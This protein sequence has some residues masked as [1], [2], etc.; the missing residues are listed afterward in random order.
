MS[1]L[2]ENERKQIIG[3]AD[4][5]I[6]HVIQ[7]V[8]LKDR[9]IKRVIP[10]K[11]S[12]VHHEFVQTHEVPCISALTVLGGFQPKFNLQ[13]NEI[14]G[15]P[16]LFTLRLD[17]LNSQV[18]AVT[19]LPSLLLIDRLEVRYNGQLLQT[20][21]GEELWHQFNLLASPAQ[22]AALVT[23]MNMSTAYAGT[24]AIQPSAS[25]TYNIPFQCCFTQAEFPMWLL[26]GETNFNFFMKDTT[27]MMEAGTVSPTVTA[28]SLMVDYVKLT[29]AEREDKENLVRTYG[30][31]WNFTEVVI[32][33][34]QV[35]LTASTQSI[36]QLPNF[37]G[38]TPFMFL[39]VR[40]ATTGTGVRTYANLLE[41]TVDLTTLSGESILGG[42]P[43]R[44]NEIRLLK[45]P[46]QF[47]SQYVS[48]LT[49]YPIFISND[50]FDVLINGVHS[51]HREMDKNRSL[52]II[53]GVG[54]VQAT[55]TVNV[56]CWIY[57]TLS[58]DTKLNLTSIEMPITE[59]EKREF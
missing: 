59:N 22:L 7:D 11:Q 16:E 2:T 23:R 39:T 35:L 26:S 47:P 40:A 57:K 38:N 41:G 36:V 45:A 29:R 5:S 17:V 31:E 24:T 18:G 25:A 50:V 43:Q 27:T 6:G 19:L 21:T 14:Q 13:N 3:M 10:T 51:G 52:R 37:T 1:Q 30:M 44:L 58:L 8:R 28:I 46:F 32:Q 49:V 42:T 33:Q 9:R 20:I 55:D 34:E 56:Y 4:P 12:E 15:Y 54:W 48:T 53:P